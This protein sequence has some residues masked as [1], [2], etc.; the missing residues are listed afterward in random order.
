MKSMHE[1]MTDITHMQTMRI[2]P[3][4]CVVFEKNGIHLFTQDLR[5]MILCV[6]YKY[7]W[8]ILKSFYG[9]SDQEVGE[10][11][12]AWVK[13]NFNWNGFTVSKG[14]LGCESGDIDNSDN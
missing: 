14:L 4:N 8:C 12:N 10:Y 13:E 5:N 7:V 9:L 1:F 3:N 6:S 11:I 2:A